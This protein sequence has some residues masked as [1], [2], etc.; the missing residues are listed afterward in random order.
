M[1]SDFRLLT[2][3]LTLTLSRWAYH[4]HDAQRLQVKLIPLLDLADDR[5]HL[6]GVI[7]R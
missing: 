7:T 1:R 6:V 2:L 4:L 3:T 5:V